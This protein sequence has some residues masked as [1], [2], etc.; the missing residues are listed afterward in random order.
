MKT[1]KVERITEV[2]VLRAVAIG[3]SVVLTIAVVI[4]LGLIAAPNTTSCLL[5]GAC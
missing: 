4:L 3:Y 5:W 2:A 1:D